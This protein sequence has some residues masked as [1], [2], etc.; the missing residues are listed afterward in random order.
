ML[1]LQRNPTIA[2]HITISGGDHYNM[3]IELYSC[4][5]DDYKF[6]LYEDI[7][8]CSGVIS[9]HLVTWSD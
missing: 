5:S 8:V 3:H 4:L 7:L 9:T 1:L 6:E 2:I